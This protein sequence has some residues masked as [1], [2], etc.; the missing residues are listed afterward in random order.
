VAEDTAAGHQLLWGC[1]VQGKEERRAA[2]GMGGDHHSRLDCMLA[3]E[4]WMV[5]QRRAAE[6]KVAG[7]LPQWGCTEEEIGWVE[8]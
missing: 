1:T 4:N 3:V 2:V 6:D 5:E 7:R 8:P